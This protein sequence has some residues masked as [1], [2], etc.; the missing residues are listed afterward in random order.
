MTKVSDDMLNSGI[1]NSTKMTRGAVQAAACVT[2]PILTDQV[3]MVEIAKI[4]IG[5]ADWLYEWHDV[6]RTYLD[7]A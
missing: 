7:T 3:L 2:A 4:P 1:I 5:I 6:K